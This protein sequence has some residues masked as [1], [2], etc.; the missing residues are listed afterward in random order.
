MTGAQLGSPLSW[1]SHSLRLHSVDC[2]GE[3][4][5]VRQADRDNRIVQDPRLLT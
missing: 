5:L 3:P 4:A 1:T 2:R